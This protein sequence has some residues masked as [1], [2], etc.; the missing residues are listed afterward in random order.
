MTNFLR[1]LCVILIGISVGFLA[2]K[3]MKSMNLQKSQTMTNA[4]QVKKMILKYKKPARIEVQ[5]FVKSADSRFQKDI[6]D[7]KNLKIALDTNSNYYIELQMFTDE[8]DL[9]APLVIQCRFLDAKSKNLIQEQ[10]L[11]L[12]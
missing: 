10:S 4:Y 12:F 7:I 2:Y 5:N 8:S 6:Q 11:N 1:T 3:K 9:K